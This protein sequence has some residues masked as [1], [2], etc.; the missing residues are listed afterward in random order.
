MNQQTLLIIA[1]LVLLMVLAA[2]LI[3][4]RPSRI[5]LT[6]KPLMTL[7]ERETIAY[8]EA[9]VPHCRVHAQ[10]AMSA[11]LKPE[12]G[13]AKRADTALRNRISQKR[14]DF[15]LEER[16]TGTI[17]ALVE[18]DDRTHNTATDQKRDALTA[19][20]GYRTI[21]LSESE[22]PT[23]LNVRARLH[24]ELSASPSSSAQS[25]NAGSPTILALA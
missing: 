21:R 13:L 18:L 8:I 6:S 23:M 5:R 1:G 19:A 17:V 10:V 24:Q 3:R 4:A 9:A 2:G 20:G 22:R 25:V 12:R 14:I 15:V 16:T 7:I 11:L